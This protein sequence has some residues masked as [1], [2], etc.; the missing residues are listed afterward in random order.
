[1]VTA[2]MDRFVGVPGAEPKEPRPGSKQTSEEEE[3]GNPQTN[4]GERLQNPRQLE[5]AKIKEKNKSDA[6]LER[7]AL[8]VRLWRSKSNEP[9]S[10]VPIGLW[11]AGAKGE[12]GCPKTGEELL[13]YSPS[14]CC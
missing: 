14:C 10:L 12:L 13:M 1:M 4:R 9:S 11:G 8:E 3:S 6:P 5:E 2:S 7:A